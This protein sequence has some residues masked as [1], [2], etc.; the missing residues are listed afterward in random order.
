MNRDNPTSDSFSLVEVTVALAVAAFSLIAIF[1]LLPIGAQTHRA[2]IGQTAAVSILSSVIADMRSTPA[3]N[4]TSSLF[5]ITFGRPTTLYFDGTGKSSSV[6]D[7]TSRYRV[8]ISFP[9]APPGAF[10]PTFAYLN[11]TWPAAAS[12]PSASGSAETF[13]IF[14]RN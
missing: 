13:A 4:P 9:A 2:G 11:V 8:T 5:G 10:A 14:D 3:M 7:A 1:G 12:I 6:I